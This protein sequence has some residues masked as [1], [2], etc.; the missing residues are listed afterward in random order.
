MVT[1]LLLRHARAAP[2]ERGDDA[3]RPLTNEGRADAVE[4]GRFLAERG[5]H[6]GRAL[7]SP[8]ART[9]QTLEGVEKGSGWAVPAVYDPALYNGTA[10]QLRAALASMADEVATVLMVAHNPAVAELA[11]SVATSGAQEDLEAMRAR[12]PPCGLVVLTF[13]PSRWRDLGGGRLEHFVTPD[14]LRA[15]RQAGRRAS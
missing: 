15:D 4:L 1:L 13:A 12:F 14:A 7:V 3:A 6:P 2:Q 8:S 9:R 10:A 5:H 11:L